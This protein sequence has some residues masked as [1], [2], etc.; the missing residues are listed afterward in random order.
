[1]FGVSWRIEHHWR[2]KCTSLEWLDASVS[3]NMQSFLQALIKKISL[4]GFRR[5]TFNR[6]FLSEP[7]QWDGNYARMYALNKFEHYKV[8]ALHRLKMIRVA[9]PA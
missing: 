7:T 8:K 6:Q 9:Y 4:N 2:L 1:M 5:T 3:W